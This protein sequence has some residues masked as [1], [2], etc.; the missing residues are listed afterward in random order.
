V[1]ARLKDFVRDGGGL[2]ISAGDRVDPRAYNAAL[3]P[4]LPC[5]LL[6]RG[7]GAALDIDSGSGGPLMPGGPSGL[8]KVTVARRL[9]LE[10]EHG[11]QLTFDDGAP[12]VAVGEAGRGQA[13][14]LATS[15]DDDWSDLPLRP[16]YLPLL[17]N[18]LRHTSRTHDLQSG[19]VQPGATV[20]IP[21]PPGAARLEVVTPAGLRRRY[22]DL[23]DESRVEF[24][25]TRAAGPYRVMVSSAGGALVDAPR[26]AFV[27]EAPRDESDLTPDPEARQLVS[28]ERGGGGATVHRSLAS[29][30][31]LLFGV[32]VIGEGL[33]R[34]RRG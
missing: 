18:L 8:S 17:V 20:R 34:L 27:V 9:M 13:A 15:L 23:D 12:A 25:D 24:S 30:I 16:G 19:P 33:V 28:G 11:A 3:G 14:I 2:V 1:A 4:V 6:S 21:V 22:D 26:G 32:V 7:G 10:C 31:F 5:R 29:L